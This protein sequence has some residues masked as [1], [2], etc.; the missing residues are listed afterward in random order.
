M[1]TATQGFTHAAIFDPDDDGVIWMSQGITNA[2]LNVDEDYFTTTE[3]K[4][5]VK[6]RQSMVTFDVV[7]LETIYKLRTFA[8]NITD[9]QFVLLGHSMC[10][11]GYTDLVVNQVPGRH[12]FGL[13]ASR[14]VTLYS[15]RF[16][17]EWYQMVNLIQ[18][19]DWGTV[20][21]GV[22]DNY[23]SAGAEHNT[24][25]SSISSGVY[26]MAVTSGG[27]DAQLYTDVVVP[28]EGVTLTLSI[29]VTADLTGIAATKQI[30]LE[31]FDHAASPSSLGSN[32]TT[33][34]GTG[35]GSVAYTLPANTYTVRCY[36]MDLQTVT[37]AGDIK[38]KYPRLRVDGITTETRY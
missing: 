35:V 9:V 16:S 8:S 15:S 18:Y 4:R 31:A 26:T 1:K 3:G 27:G 30:K 20:T 22:P 29:E 10:A 24:G 37:G 12:G 36:V 32:T 2:S 19:K 34:S 23:T 17:T 14:S 33:I 11:Q 6:S 21:A 38:F 25:S 13:N 28:V 7:D 5:L